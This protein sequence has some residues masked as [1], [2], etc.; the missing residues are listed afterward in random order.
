VSIA[1]DH[2]RRFQPIAFDA[3]ADPAL[4]ASVV[5]GHGVAIVRRAI[6]AR[7]MAYLDDTLGVCFHLLD[8]I[9]TWR[10]GFDG[11]D[12]PPLQHTPLIRG[13][14]LPTVSRP[15]G[16]DVHNTLYSLVAGSIL[17][18][19]WHE[20]FD[21]RQAQL[22]EEMCVVRRQVAHSPG[23]VLPFHQDGTNYVRTEFLNF[24]IPTRPSGVD[25]PGLEVVAMQPETNLEVTR[26]ESRFP[27]IEL[28]E[29]LVID[30]FGAESLFRPATQPGDVVVMNPLTIHRTWVPDGATKERLSVEVRIMPS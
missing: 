22:R 7:A 26:A 29:K 9:E 20:Y 27:T 12:L 19:V 5:A 28:D 13:D 18:R 2:E 15:L 30:R 17:G 24:W 4:V 16:M 6:P 21:G 1:N 14:L 3:A 10:S 23:D 11:P 8:V 25:S